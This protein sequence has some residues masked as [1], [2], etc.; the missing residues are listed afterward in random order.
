MD[1]EKMLESMDN[2]FT[3]LTGLSPTLWNYDVVCFGI[4]FV[5]FFVGMVYAVAKV[6]YCKHTGNSTE[7]TNN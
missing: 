1:L 4:C 3:S 7:K 6:Q 5:L 2:A